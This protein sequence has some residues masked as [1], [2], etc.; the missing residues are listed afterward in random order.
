MGG[1]IFADSEGSGKGTTVTFYMPLVRTLE[2]PAEEADMAPFGGDASY[3]GGASGAL[4]EVSGAFDDGDLPAAAARNEGPASAGGAW[5]LTQAE[6]TP[7]SSLAL[8]EPPSLDAFA[9][10]ESTAESSLDGGSFASAGASAISSAGASAG[11]STGGVAGPSAP[12]SAPALAP[13]WEPFRGLSF[14]K[15]G[16]ILG[17]SQAPQPSR[18]SP[19]AAKWAPAALSGRVLA[20]EDDR[21]SQLVLRKTLQ[22]LGFDPVVVGDGQQALDAWR[23][24]PGLFDMVSARSRRQWPSRS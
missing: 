23:D 21:A 16:G 17:A 4:A 22:K 7:S 24:E 5:R 19:G 18:L 12:A 15:L 20:A 6:A 1:E 3:W 14:P 8:S 11:A 2:T 9:L 10:G 13:L